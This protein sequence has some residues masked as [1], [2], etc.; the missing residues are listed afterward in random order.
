MLL[1]LQKTEKLQVQ[2]L[3]TIASF[4]LSSRATWE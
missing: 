2:Y 3:L 1:I 4:P